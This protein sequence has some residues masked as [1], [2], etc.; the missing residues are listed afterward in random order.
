VLMECIVGPTSTMIGQTIREL[1][2]RRRFGVLVLA[3]HRQ[4]EN[5]RRNVADV[6]LATGD[7]L[8]VAGPRPVIRRIRESGEFLLLSDVPGSQPGK[9]PRRISLAIVLGVVVLA[10]FNFMPISVLALT[11]AALM[12][13]LGCLKV[14]DAYRS[15]HWQT[16]FL[17]CGMLAIGKAMETTHATGYL[18]QQLVGSGTELPPR[19]LLSLLFLFTSLFTQFLSN[20]AV[21]VLCTPVALHLAEAA[22]VDA[23]PFVIAVAMGASACFATP[24]GYQT[25]TLVFAAG[26]YHFR[27]FLRMG[28]PLNL[29]VW[30]TGSLL[31]PWIWPF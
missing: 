19:L 20:N 27:D 12:L 5:L 6:R 28:I 3:V 2:L 18:V 29:L 24:F 15:L 31:I 30:G 10:A 1:D 4:G 17:I 26:G 21:A 11:G 22:G 13:V 14:E 9:R 8:L 7:I 25:N 16:L 23:R